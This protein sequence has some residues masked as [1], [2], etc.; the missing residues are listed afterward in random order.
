MD[1]GVATRTEAIGTVD[2]PT[3]ERHEIRAE[4]AV[5]RSGKEKNPASLKAS[6]GS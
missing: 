5:I 4:K 3:V 6:P 2:G 1:A